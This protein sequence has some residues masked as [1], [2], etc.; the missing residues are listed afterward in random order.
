MDSRVRFIRKEDEEEIER[1]HREE[2]ARYQASEHSREERVL[3]DGD[4]CWEEEGG[5]EVL[6]D[7]LDL[8]EEL[9]EDIVADGEEVLDSKVKQ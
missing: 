3:E 9:E 1:R 8:E 5:E 4:K 7:D 6:G 2:S